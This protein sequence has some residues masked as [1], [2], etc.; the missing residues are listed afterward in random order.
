MQ[1]SIKRLASLT[2]GLLVEVEGQSFEKR[3]SLFLPLLHNCLSLFDPQ[4]PDSVP[5]EESATENAVSEQ[6]DDIEEEDKGAG[7][8]EST[9]DATGMENG[10]TENVE[11]EMDVE[12]S[13]GGDDSEVPSKDY[14]S[15]SVGLLDRVLFS[16]LLTLRKICSECSVLRVSTH[17]ETMNMIWGEWLLSLLMEF[18]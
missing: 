12:E 11:S 13:A 5:V 7:G 16:S 17:R 4:A 15:T 10:I 6:H 3:L 14:Q 9:S 1:L 8:D 18:G 2:L